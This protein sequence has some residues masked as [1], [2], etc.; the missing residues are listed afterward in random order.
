MPSAAERQQIA[1]AIERILEMRPDQVKY[2][3]H[4]LRSWRVFRTDGITLMRRAIKR[5]IHDKP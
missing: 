4:L 1:D 3:E 5:A 2:A